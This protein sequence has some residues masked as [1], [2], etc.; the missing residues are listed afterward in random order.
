VVKFPDLSNPDI[1]AIPRE[2]IPGLLFLLASRLLEMASIPDRDSPMPDRLITVE[3]AAERL[4]FTEQ[5]LYGLI[6][7]GKF[8]A[9]REGKYYRI[10]E[11]DLSAWI[12]EHREKSIDNE[13][14]QSYSKRYGR[15]RTQT[16]QA[17]NGTHSAANVR[18]NRRESQY[19][20]PMGAGRVDDIR[21]RLKVHSTSGNDGNTGQLEG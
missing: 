10:R 6:R 17:V 7:N 2:Q 3:V 8:P 16:D 18:Q 19:N 20:R 11:S 14:Y 5:Y 9:I 21:T 4:A 12:E 13:L 15:K 1:S